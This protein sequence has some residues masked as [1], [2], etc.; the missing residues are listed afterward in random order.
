MFQETF[1][2]K[3]YMLYWILTHIARFPSNEIVVGEN[4]VLKF[5]ERFD[6]TSNRAFVLH[7]PKSLSSW[8]SGFFINFFTYCVFIYQVPTIIAIYKYDIYYLIP[9]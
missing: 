9:D 8:T 1:R 5:L 6:I 4:D 7:D 2:R 3:N